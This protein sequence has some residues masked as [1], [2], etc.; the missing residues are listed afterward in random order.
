MGSSIPLSCP[1][2]KYEA[3]ATAVAAAKLSKKT[4][5]GGNS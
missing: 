2:G 3:G 1:Y 4:G 5:N